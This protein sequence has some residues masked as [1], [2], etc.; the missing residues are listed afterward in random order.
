[1]KKRKIT[2]RFEKLSLLLLTMVFLGVN[3]VKADLISYPRLN[4]C[5]DPEDIL[6][7]VDEPIEDLTCDSIF[8]LS[9]HE[10]LD[11]LPIVEVEPPKNSQTDSGQL[12]Y[13]NLFQNNLFN[14]P[15][16]PENTSKELN[17]TPEEQPSQ[18]SPESLTTPIQAK[19]EQP[20]P[21]PATPEQPNPAPATTQ[22]N[23][24][25]PSPSNPSTNPPST[26]TLPPPSAPNAP[27]TTPTATPNQ[28]NPASLPNQAPLN[29]NSV[30][31]N[32][33]PQQTVPQTPIFQS[34][35]A[36]APL[37]A[38]ANST[39]INAQPSTINTAA[40]TSGTEPQ[41]TILINF[42]NVAITEYLR[43]ISR[44][45]NKN[46][47]FDENDLQFTV[48]IV[49]EEPTTIDNIMTALLQELR[50]HD[51]ELIEQDNTI[52]IH[53]NSKVSAISKVV[54]EDMN[55]S[56]VQNA[57]IVTKVFRLNTLEADRAA[58]ILK[59][60]VSAAALVEV[61]KETNH[62][63]ITDLSSNVR[64][65]SALLKS[66]RQPSKW[67]CHRTVCGEHTTH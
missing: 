38:P 22:P 23:P 8:P 47:V 61:L 45:S 35:I 41:K 55:V 10:G 24:A 65:I 37:G 3:H 30:V 56:D 40:L 11:L 60:M 28:A 36:P 5:V 51:L 31:P 50:I 42:N 19:P 12:F 14:A 6:Y 59:P 62:L 7:S 67:S 20:T 52:I 44:I 46:F 17:L 48:T 18:T 21:N 15:K 9:E 58:V 54:P 27:A 16:S 66:L 33:T 43:F 29:P 63:I 39:T 57:D 53:H 32:Q 49:S 26:Q 4:Q 64:E 34:P 25:A 13:P 1:M 2:L